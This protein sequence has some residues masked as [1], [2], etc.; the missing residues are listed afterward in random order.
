LT[1]LQNITQPL[2][3]DYIQPGS[4]ILITGPPGIGKTIFCRNIAAGCSK[5]GTGVVYVTLDSA[6]RDIEESIHSQY[7]LKGTP[8]KIIFV[9]CYSWLTGEMKGPYCISH[10][11]N[12]GDLSVKLFTALQEKGPQS[13]VIFDSISTLFVY[14]VENEVIRFLQVNVA[15]IRQMGCFGIWTVE[16][17]V[18]SPAL[19][20]TLRHIM[21]VTLELRFEETSTLERR[22]RVHTCRSSTHST[23]WFPFEI[24]DRGILEIENG[25]SKADT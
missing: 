12:L 8:N 4:S 11:S 20:N 18:H 17:G 19:Y 22:M 7:D 1:V 24:K 25:D 5:A 10:L 23:Q 3:I 13:A 9:D 14:N 2:R 15:R 16:E 21:D 6:P